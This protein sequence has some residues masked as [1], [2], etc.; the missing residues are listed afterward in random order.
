MVTKNSLIIRRSRVKMPLLNGLA[1]LPLKSLLWR[2]I[3]QSRILRKMPVSAPQLRACAVRPCS[4][5]SEEFTVE[6]NFTVTDLEE[7]ACV[8]STHLRMR[9]VRP[10]SLTSEEFTVEDNS[11]VTDLEEDAF[12]V[13]ST[14]PRMRSAP[15]LSYLWRV[16]CGG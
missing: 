16:C 4:L 14:A 5:T 15:L 11:T 10:Y 13:C 9:S 8:C 3:L 6:D 1:L 2:I 12:C 7:D